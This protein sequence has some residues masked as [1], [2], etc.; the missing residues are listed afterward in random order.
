[1]KLVAGYIY[2][3]YAR[4]L[5]NNLNLSYTSFMCLMAILEQYPVIYVQIYFKVSS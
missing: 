2:A 5:W 4:S 1:M 3:K